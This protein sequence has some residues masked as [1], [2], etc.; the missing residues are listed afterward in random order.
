MADC[1]DQILCS[2]SSACDVAITDE[3]G[4]EI[5]TRFL[6]D[7]DTI[8]FRVGNRVGYTLN[9][10]QFQPI[11]GEPYDVIVDDLGDGMYM[12]TAICGG[13]FIANYSMDLYVVTVVP[14][15]PLHGRTLGSGAYPYRTV[16]TISATEYPGYHFNGWYID[17]E[18]ISRDIEYHYT[19]TGNVT[20]VGEFVADEYSIVGRPNDRNLGE[21]TGSGVY[22]DGTVVT[23]TAIPYQGTTFISWDDG[24]TNPI[25]TITVTGNETHIAIFEKNYYTVTVLIV[26]QSSTRGS[27]V[28]GVVTGSG[29]Y[30]YG[31]T[32]SLNASPN[33]GFSFVSWDDGA[34]TTTGTT[35]YSFTVTGNMTITATFDDAMYT[36][37]LSS[38][39][40][41]GGYVTNGISPALFNGGTYAYGTV[42]TAVAVPYAGYAFSKWSD[43]ELSDTRTFTMDI[44]YSPIALFTKQATKFTLRINYNSTMGKVVIMDGGVD[45]SSYVSG[46]VY[47]T[48]DEGTILTA[49]VTEISPYVFKRWDDSTSEGLTRTFTVNSNI[50]RTVYFEDNT[51]YTL[52][53]CSSTAAIWSYG[54]FIVRYDSGT[55]SVTIDA[56]RT[57][58]T[59]PNSTDVEIE[60]VEDDPT[61][62]FHDWVLTQQCTG[63]IVNRNTLS[64]NS[65]SCSD[66]IC[67]V[68]DSPAPTQ[69]NLCICSD[70]DFSKGAYRIQYSGGT[71]VISQDSQSLCVPVDAGSN[72][73]IYFTNITGET[74]TWDKRQINA[75]SYQ[76]SGLTF[77][78]GGINGDNT[79]CAVVDTPPLNWFYVE[80]VSGSPNILLFTK[81]TFATPITIETST[82][83]NT[84]STL[85]T[86]DDSIV[87][88]MQIPANGKVYLRANTQ[89]W[90][91]TFINCSGYFNVGGD[92]MS[93][94]YGSNYDGT[95]TQFPSA[96]TTFYNL[97]V[98]AGS[99]LLNAGDLILPATTLTAF[100]Y[101]HMFM[102][103]SGLKYGPD[104]PAT[105][106]GDECYREMFFGCTSLVKTPDLPATVLK[107]LCY[108]CMFKNC[109]SLTNAPDLL[110]DT[111]AEE[112][113]ASMFENCTLLTETPILYSDTLTTNCYAHMF[114]GCTS[115]SKVTCLATNI[116]ASNCVYSWL[117]DVNPSGTFYKDSSMQSW[118]SGYSGIP[119]GWTVTDY[120][121]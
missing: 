6:H 92:I 41:N 98:N 22:A 31:A 103:C 25:K 84:W 28:C 93:L 44:D 13:Q 106:L 82:D 91:G 52:S 9:G 37:V 1:L 104:L 3:N 47:A 56:A 111:L 4:L 100:A 80:D 96:Q 20:I 18:L 26:N 5:D 79:V 88:S 73:Q 99:A 29:S 51:Q 23:L 77:N 8:Y 21:V 46:Y 27:E 34:T 10:F 58:I 63:Y 97:F 65:L 119:S 89:T 38:Q 24:D 118:P 86:T 94:L 40:S 42:V 53:F 45:V 55:Q 117:Y 12:T 60:Y 64:I 116:S 75:A 110:A 107:R 32:V 74:F 15:D 16:I 87:L 2:E 36:L 105:A 49:I 61:Y 112:C 62:P 30:P 17:G 14:D 43:G 48:V 57:S 72:A 66:D 54:H 59:L 70:A 35:T 39:P 76:E 90:N 115:L 81:L 85:G 114:Y 113:C 50:N 19:V 11:G 7:G 71:A 95:Q 78:L 68:L 121:P 101:K 67:V 120:Q 83:R 109:S 102:E 69:Y 108:Q 33:A